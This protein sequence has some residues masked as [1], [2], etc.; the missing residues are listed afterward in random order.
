[1]D[2]IDLFE[3]GKQ[4]YAR[5]EYEGAVADFSESLGLKEDAEVLSERAV[6]YFHLRQLK[7]SLTDLNRA[8]ELQPSNPYRYSSRAYV[9][10]Q[11]G[12]TAG[13]IADYEIALKLDPFDAVAHNNLGLL[14]EKMGR[15]DAAQKLVKQAD[16]LAEAQA[17]LANEREEK[18]A[19]KTANSQVA[20][21]SK[22]TNKPTQES[23]TLNQHL[24]VI[25]KVFK[26]KDT[27]REFTQF[28]SR[29]FRNKA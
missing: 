13:A 27:W 6:A 2:A 19:V 20:N 3:R 7:A 21:T 1:M 26:S 18:Q 8:Q 14:Q 9:R 15:K 17:Y 25:G 22:P 5:N 23:P 29:G 24:S 16:K 11:M 12:D 28:I 10:D 4:K